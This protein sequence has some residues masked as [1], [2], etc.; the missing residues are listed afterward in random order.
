MLTVGKPRVY[1]KTVRRDERCPTYR[2]RARFVIDELMAAHGWDIRETSPEGCRIAVVQRYSSPQEIRD[3]KETCGTVIFETNDVHLFK[4]PRFY[5]P[6]EREIVAEAD[7][8]VVTCRYMQKQ[9]ARINPKCLIAH[10]ALEDEF[11]TT[12]VPELPDSPL[13]VS[14]HGTNDNLQYVEPII[15]AFN[16]SGVDVVLKVVMPEKDAKGQSNVARC[17]SYPVKT[18]F[19]VWKQETWVREIAEAHAGIVPLPD[20]EFCRSKCGHKTYGYFALGMPVIA[21]NVPS[22][23]EVIRHGETGLLAATPEEWAE[24]MKLLTDKTLR[25]RMGKA[26]R[27]FSKH[28]SRSEVAKT[29]NSILEGVCAENNC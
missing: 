14:W 17:A 10:E 22:Y 20:T 13:R 3:L 12:P 26:G 11:W 4:D 16:E 5:N 1:W 7:Y 28:F 15:E 8:V 18:E 9:F 2:R 29:W 27:E 6:K 23:R 25:E 24:G 19:A 21:S